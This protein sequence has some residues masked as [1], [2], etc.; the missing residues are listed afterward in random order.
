MHFLRDA[1]RSTMFSRV[2]TDVF[3]QCG[4]RTQLAS[5]VRS[6][7]DFPGDHRNPKKDKLTNYAS[8][9]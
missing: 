4:G 8:T 2:L 6:Q 1:G 7:A 9:F 3:W 5:L